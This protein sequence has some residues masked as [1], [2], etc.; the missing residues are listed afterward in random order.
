[1]RTIFTCLFFFISSLT[2]A[3]S[4]YKKG[5]VKKT[6]GAVLNGYID[7]QEWGINPKTISFKTLTS[8]KEVLKFK[9]INIQSFE[10]NDFENYVSYTGRTSA[11]RTE[12][13]TL[14]TG[15]DTT[16]RQDTIFLKQLT[17]GSRITLFS[18]TD[19]IKT[20]FFIAEKGSKPIEL[21][22]HQYYE[23][24]NHTAVS[25][26]YKTQLSTLANQY[27]PGN[28]K[29]IATIDFARYAQSTLE[30]IVSA[31]NGEVIANNIK[32]KKQLV[33]F[34]AGL[35]LNQTDTKFEGTN[36]LVSAGKST[37]YLP[38]ISIGIDAFNNPTVQRL[39]FRGELSFTAITPK[40]EIPVYVIGSP[41]G[42]QTYT[43]NQY[44]T[45]FTPQILYNIYNRENLKFYLG[46]G[47]GLNFSV[48]GNNKITTKNSVFYRDQDKP[49]AFESFWT[50]FPVEAGVTL[51][52]RI[53]LYATY[54]FPAVY[55]TYS[56][57]NV[58]SKIT[59]VGIHF[60]LN[61]K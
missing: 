4:H 18:Y 2:F 34:F 37:N 46:I 52:K 57:F 59:S 32:S 49:Y 16:T 51:N 56:Y 13:P 53:E 5:S 25:I 17:S 40:F 33:R 43:F 39:V 42:S 14:P 55:S 27:N 41:D 47:A 24:N 23:D 8:D 58:S 54:S 28:R 11:D 48:Y 12:F 26:K 1:M 6:D 60:L 29:L 38:K 61:K 50:N 44:T 9:P 35:T 10:I 3:Q 30:K 20:R 19:E 15:L 22:Y 21:I 7:Y 36:P 31:I 45:T